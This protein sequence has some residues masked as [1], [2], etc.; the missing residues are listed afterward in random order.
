MASLQ[1][2]GPCR[3]PTE[4]G[5]FRLY[6]FRA[7][8]SSDVHVALVF[9]EVEAGREVLVRVHS[10]CLTGETLGSLRCDCGPQLQAAMR[11][12]AQAGRGAILYLR[13]EGRGIGLFD[14]IRAY[15]LQDHGA[16]TVDA[17]TELGLPV[18]ARDYGVAARILDLL[19]IRSILL[20]T[21]N[22]QKC[23]GLADAGIVI[24]GSVPIAAPANAE[25]ETYLQTKALRMGHLLDCLPF[26][27]PV[28][29]PR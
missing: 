10:E 7:R 24:V 1:Q 23:R 18:D 2:S 8:G 14:K 22:P 3:L 26:V 25:N 12:V 13:Q 27:A 19:G 5:V 29:A 4:Q 11:Q 17:N 9:G 6:G 21:N 15:E 16:D 28:A 20:M